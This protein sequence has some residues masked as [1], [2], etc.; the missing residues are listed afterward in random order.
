MEQRTNEW[1]ASRL[2]KLTASRMNDARD[3]LAKGGE[4][5]KRKNYRFQ[6]IAERL[7]GEPTP[8]FENSAMRFGTECEPMARTAYEAETG[9]MVL[10]VGFIGHPRIEWAGA[11]PDGFVGDDG[12]IEIKCPETITHIQNMLHGGVPE[13]YHNQILWQLACTGRKWC[14]FISF[15]PRMPEDLQLYIK[16]FEPTKEQ[17]QE[18]EAK[19]V[20]F[21]NSVS[22]L[23]DQVT[24]Q[25]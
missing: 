5:Q 24:G 20:E 13:Q 10:E 1:Y 9:S 19:A 2:G 12:C 23:Y 11:S 17:I 21:L 15:D 14:D 4:G 6:L 16:R 25:K 8:F 22:D 18:I 3:F 7:T